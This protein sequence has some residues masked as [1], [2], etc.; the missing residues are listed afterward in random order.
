MG[1]LIVR[2]F[3]E[4]LLAGALIIIF[5]FACVA[6]IVFVYHLAMPPDDVT[7]TS[8]DDNEDADGYE[9]DYF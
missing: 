5:G 6:G 2:A 9:D 3:C 1:W 7:D 8:L 4:A